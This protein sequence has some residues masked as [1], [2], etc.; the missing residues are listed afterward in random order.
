VPNEERPAIQLDDDDRNCLHAG[1]SRSGKR[2]IVSVVPRGR[3]HDASQIELDP[4][5]VERLKEFLAEH[6]RPEG[7]SLATREREVR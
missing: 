4:A 5:Q 2:L 1:W 7:D 6:S 3:W